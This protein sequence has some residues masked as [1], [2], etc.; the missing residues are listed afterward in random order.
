M[1]KKKVKEIAERVAA[2]I[3]QAKENEALEK[4]R[5]ESG[6]STSEFKLNRSIMFLVVALAALAGYDMTNEQQV[7]LVTAVGG[8]ITSGGVAYGVIRN[9]RKNAADKV[10]AAQ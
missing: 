5:V 2:E 1:E 9:W 8:L 10:A 4:A 7:E 3:V 6:S